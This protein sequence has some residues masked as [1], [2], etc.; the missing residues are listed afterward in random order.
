MPLDPLRNPYTPGAGQAPAV[1]S[2][3]GQELED[4]ETRLRRLENGRAAQC[5]LVVGLRGVGK[6]VLLSTFSRAALRRDWV[7]A[8]HELTP[9][10]DLLATTAR[11]AR[12]CLLELSPPS[13]WS[14]AAARVA[15]LLSGFEVSYRLAGLAV[16]RSAADAQPASGDPAQD[17]AAL[18]VALGQAAQDHGRGVVLLLDELQFAAAEPLGALVAGLHKVAQRSL[19]LTA[20]AAGLPQTRGVLAE[21]ASYSERMFD[22]REVGALDVQDARAALAEPAAA[23]GVAFDDDAVG[24]A[25]RFSEGYPFFLQ[26]FGDQVWRLASDER[27]EAEDV[28]RAAPQVVATL[29]R[30]FFTFRTDGLPVA[31]RRYLR[32]MAELPAQGRSSGEVARVLGL[33]S[34]APIGQ[35]REALIRRGLIYAPRLGFADFTVPQFADYLRRHFELEK[36]VPRRR[37]SSS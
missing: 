21:A 12:Q 7:V 20:V 28:Q 23:E 19:P 15:D 18:L 16:S 32:A 3:R 11:L 30:R 29:D 25:V 31:Q 6:T 1:L 13:G 10:G 9:T 8:E 26:V 17:V 35:T 37:G 14:R 36:H 22:T 5:T 33:A 34:S 2:G 27:I 24:E 4:F